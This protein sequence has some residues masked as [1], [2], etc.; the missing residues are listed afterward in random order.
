MRHSRK[1]QR[2]TASSQADV[3]VSE[4]F[5]H[6][7]R[8]AAPAVE[9]QEHQPEWCTADFENDGGELVCVRDSLLRVAVALGID[10]PL[11]VLV[12]SPRVS[13]GHQ[14]EEGHRAPAPD[15]TTHEEM[16]GA[17]RRT[18]SER[19]KISIELLLTAR[20][21]NGSTARKFTNCLQQGGQGIW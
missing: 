15:E 21:E 6:R 16:L 20:D 13:V 9:R 18:Q 17:D 8:P 12:M 7:R 14:V 19:G 5:R 1:A 3:H 11:R 10:D 2:P 4:Q